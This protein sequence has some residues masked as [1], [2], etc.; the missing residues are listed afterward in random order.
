[1][2]GKPVSHVMLTNSFSMSTTGYGVRRYQKLYVYWPMAVHPDLR[3]ALLIGYGVGNT[4]KAM[5]DSS[6]LELIDVV[7]LARDILAMNRLVIR[8][9]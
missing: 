6:S 2:T 9:R 1:M 7:D 3:R 8:T 5:T 4:A